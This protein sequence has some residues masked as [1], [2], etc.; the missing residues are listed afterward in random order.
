MSQIF[1]IKI[2]ISLGKIPLC[3]SLATVKFLEQP[4]LEPQWVQAAVKLEY[5]SYSRI[6]PRARVL[7]LGTLSFGSRP[8]LTHS[9]SWVGS[10]TPGSSTDLWFCLSSPLEGWFLSFTGHS[11]NAARSV[12]SHI[13]ERLLDVCW[14]MESPIPSY[15]KETV[16]L[17][18]QP[19][20]DMTLA[21]LL[22]QEH[23]AASRDRKISELRR[24]ADW[25]HTQLICK[26]KWAI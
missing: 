8:W 5:A 22:F 11:I 26:L 15:G 17:M 24:Q 1:C 19:P 21:A 7:A 9:S 18:P 12:S 25:G 6:A 2:S 20:Q 23:W 16:Y 3:C 10:A 14:S 13:L 4:C